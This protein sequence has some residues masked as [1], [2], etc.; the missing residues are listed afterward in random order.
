MKKYL[1]AVIL[2][3]IAM[4]LFLLFMGSDDPVANRVGYMKIGPWMAS[5]YLVCSIGLNRYKTSGFIGS[6]LGSLSILAFNLVMLI[7]SVGRP[8]P[9]ISL[10]FGGRMLF[11]L[12][13]L[14]IVISFS[15]RRG[16]SNGEKA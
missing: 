16:R 8:H 15:R 9:L 14:D 2:A 10:Q 7:M 13:L 4:G 11:G 1:A 3:I 12:A 6:F 5:F